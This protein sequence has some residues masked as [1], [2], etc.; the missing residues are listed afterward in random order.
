[1]PKPLT[2]AELAQAGKMGRD[3]SLADAWAVIERAMA[4][5]QG[6]LRFRMPGEV[7]KRGADDGGRTRDLRLAK[8]NRHGDDPQL[9]R[10]AQPSDLPA[11]AALLRAAGL[12]L[13]G[14]RDARVWV[15]QGE[16]RIL[17]AAGLEVRPPHGLLRSVVVDAG[18]RGRGVGRDLV[19]RVRDEGRCLG[20]RELWLL[21]VD[22]ERY[23]ARLGF[24]PRARSEAPG[25]LAGS[26]EL[27]GACPETATL[28][29]S[30]LP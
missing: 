22:A 16:G 28:M 26:A 14:L 9:L 17:G 24:E 1:V 10:P 19:A 18:A 27:R 7:S 3:P 25:E 12:P 29:R 15:A 8:P 6:R 13:D 2:A 11:V 30:V 5:I 21:T 23:F 20:L 4:D